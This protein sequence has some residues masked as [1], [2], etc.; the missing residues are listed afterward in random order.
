VPA[1]ADDGATFATLGAV[2]AIVP[3]RSANAPGTADAEA[4]R[5]AVAEAAAD[6][7]TGPPDLSVRLRSAGAAQQRAPS[8]EVRRRLAAAWNS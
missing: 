1:T 8:I 2:H 5:A 4:A 3:V 7:L 6:A